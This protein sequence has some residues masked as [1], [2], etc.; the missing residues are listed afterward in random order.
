MRPLLHSI[1]VGQAVQ[2]VDAEAGVGGEE[3]E[4]VV[5]SSTTRHRLGVSSLDEL[6]CRAPEQLYSVF[7]E[8]VKGVMLRFNAPR[9]SRFSLR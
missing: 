2:P 3:D 7:K 6:S 8:K 5:E 4:G 1:V 9:R